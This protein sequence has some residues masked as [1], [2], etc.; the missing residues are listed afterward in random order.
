MSPAR[1]VIAAIVN[2]VAGRRTM[3]PR[4]QRIQKLLRLRGATLDILLT[5]APGDAQRL[6]EGIGSE[7]EALLVAGGD[8]TAGEVV[9]GLGPAAPPLLLFRAGTENLAAREF[10][11]PVDPAEVVETLLDSPAIRC[12]LGEI[13]GRRFL[14]IAG[15]GFDA[16]CVMR[17]SRV[18]RGHITHADY[19]WPLWRAFW[20]YGFPALRFEADGQV[21]FDGRGLAIIGNISRYSVGMQLLPDAQFDDGLL[22][23]GVFPCSTRIGLV[24]HSVS[25]LLA[26]K[27]GERRAPSWRFRE[28]RV[29]SCDAVPIEIDGEFGGRLPA[30]CRVLPNRIRLLA[31][32]RR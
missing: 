23:L 10:G 19:F 25:A 5:Q 29:T 20:A 14:A 27:G 9:N 12:D 26:G 21:I 13:N 6:A 3:L 11:M 28:L 30:T 24:R 22:N 1:H 16:E 4:V 18:R 31:G 7:V 2:P 32:A 17:M 8:G 15:I